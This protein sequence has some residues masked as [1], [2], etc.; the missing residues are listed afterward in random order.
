MGG[1]RNKVPDGW[2]GCPQN[3]NYLIAGKFMALKTP[4]CD[5]FENNLVP[6]D[7]YPP[8][9]I[10][11]RAKR[12]KVR[13]GLWIDLTNTDRYYKKESIEYEGCKY[14]KL[15]CPGH[16]DCP[17][18]EA[19]NSFIHIVDKFVKE[20]P[21]DCIAVHCTHGFNRTGFLIV[22]FL[23]EKLNIDVDEAVK[24]FAD[25]RPPGIYRGNYI[26]ELFKR[27]GVASEAPS[28]P[29]LPPWCGDR[30]LR[31]RRR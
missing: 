9:E 27:Y 28:A 25:A 15:G 6:G 14:V 8:N 29:K 4:L 16:G 26:S 13:I 11:V 12:N 31:R 21:S 23:V 3:G 19:T 20:Q 17:S 5:R 2:I 18:I 24:L 10:F 1:G 30:H 7:T 22:S